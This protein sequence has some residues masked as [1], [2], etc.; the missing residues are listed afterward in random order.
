[1]MVVSKKWNGDAVKVLTAYRDQLEAKT[2]FDS[3]IAKNTLDEAAASVGIGT[4]KILQAARLA[5]TGLSGGPDLMMIMEIIGKNEVMKRI[6]HALKTLQ[7]K[8]S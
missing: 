5:I 3:V 2:E 1:M 7:V 4:G 6:D 8:V